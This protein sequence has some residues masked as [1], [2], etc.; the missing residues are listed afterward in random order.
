M[1]ACSFWDKTLLPT[2][3]TTIDKTIEESLWRRNQSESNKNMS[4]WTSESDKRR[5]IVY[6]KHQ[7]DV[8]KNKSK[9]Y[10]N[11]VLKS[12]YVYEC[13]TL[14]NKEIVKY[15][16]SLLLSTNIGN[17]K[18]ISE[19]NNK[20]EYEKEDLIL[21][22]NHF[23]SPKDRKAEYASFPNHYQTLEVVIKSKNFIENKN[24]QKT[25]WNVAKSGLRKSL[26]RNKPTYITNVTEIIKHLPCQ[27]ELGCGAAFEAGVP[28]LHELHDTYFINEPFTKKFIITADKDLLMK[29]YIL[30]PA[31]EFKQTSR[32]YAKV[33]TAKLTP[34]YKILKRLHDKNY[35]VGPIITNNFDGVHLRLG[36]P[37]LYIRTYTESEVMPNI[38]F[39]P[40]AKSLLV[41]GCH[42]DRRNIEMK[43]RQQGLKVIY[44]DP[45]GWNVDDIFFQYLL[46]SPQ[47]TDLIYNKGASKAFIEIEKKLLFKK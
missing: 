46:E 41:V 30:N 19:T 44:V 7:Y 10:R 9:K 13:F 34:F 32:F 39:H 14:P 17:W 20:I 12:T 1:K 31:K 5:K 45:E 27:I 22:I 38:E 16:K 21:N 37:E 47:Q 8:I 23:V 40:K 33:L 28:P 25:I 29:H 4:G 36:I 35:V 6:Y 24:L 11:L 42:A 18:K 15:K 3:G 26:P 2:K 43:A